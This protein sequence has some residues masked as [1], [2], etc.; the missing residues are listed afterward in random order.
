MSQSRMSVAWKSRFQKHHSQRILQNEVRE[1]PS[2]LVQRVRK[3]VLF[4]ERH[5]LLPVWSINSNALP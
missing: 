4:D 5:A 1:T 3:D 2:I